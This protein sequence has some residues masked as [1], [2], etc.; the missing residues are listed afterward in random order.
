MVCHRE[1]YAQFLIFGHKV[2][3]KPTSF[4]LGEKDFE[5]LNCLL[6]RT[7]AGIRNNI[8]FKSKQDIS[9]QP[10]VSVSTISSS[11]RDIDQ[12]FEPVYSP[13]LPQRFS[14]F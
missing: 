4:Y 10:I 6:F 9:L 7:T 8:V 5:L 12:Q 3:G 14:D 11:S 2:R 1:L 13:W